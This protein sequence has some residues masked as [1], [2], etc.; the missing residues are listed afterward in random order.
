M[1]AMRQSWTDD[2]MDHLSERMEER[3]DAV[4]RRFGE[5]DRRLD[6]V[7]AHLQELGARFNSLQQALLLA[8]F[9]MLGAVLTALVAAL[10]I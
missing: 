1:E 10:A 9:G 8:T 3:F 5:V 7:D 2:R 4:D 6:H